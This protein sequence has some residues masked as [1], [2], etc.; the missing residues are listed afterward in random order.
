MLGG[1]SLQGLRVPM[2]P[3]LGA[4]YC[5]VQYTTLYRVHA[6]RRVVFI[7][8]LTIGTLLSHSAIAMAS[9]TI[10]EGRWR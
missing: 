8:V 4:K 7:I 1:V 3:M 2:V 9:C 10:M 6:C 5:V